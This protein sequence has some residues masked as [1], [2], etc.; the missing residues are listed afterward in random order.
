[1]RL[2]RPVASG[3][4]GFSAAS[5]RGLIEAAW[6]RTTS[7]PWAS[8]P[9]HRAAASLKHGDLAEAQRAAQGFPRHRA[10]ASLKRGFRLDLSDTL[11]RGF[12]RHR[13]A[14][15]LKQGADRLMMQAIRGFPR[16]RAAASLKRWS[17]RGARRQPDGFSAASGRGLIE[18]H[19]AHDARSGAPKFSAASGRGLIEARTC[20]GCCPTG[21]AAFSAA[22]GRG[23]IEA[24]RLDFNAAILLRCFPRHRAA[25]SLKPLRAAGRFG[26]ARTFS[27]ASG[28][29][30]IEAW[31]TAMSWTTTSCVFRGIGPRPH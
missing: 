26:G 7:S 2:A 24:A 11:P 27:A 22:S 28:R 23:L 15:S 19:A 13:A 14:A 9:R 17:P 25:A 4:G 6:A 29:G 12:P 30:L 3:P 31:L 16:H 1:M 18:A 8:F 21:K 10:A 20:A 5:G